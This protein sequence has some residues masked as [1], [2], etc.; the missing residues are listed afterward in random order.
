MKKKS[1]IFASILLITVLSVLLVGCNKTYNSNG[2]WGENELICCDSLFIHNVTCMDQESVRTTVSEYTEAVAPFCAK[3]EPFR[4]YT[5]V[6]TELGGSQYDPY[7]V[8]VKDNK[9]YEI[10]MVN[11]QEQLSLDYYFREEPLVLITISHMDPKEDVLIVD[12]QWFCV[13]SAANYA[14]LFN[15][16]Q[17]YGGGEITRIN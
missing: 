17:T 10:N 9:R 8:F 3:V 13:M 15:E 14:E 12:W 16:V 2:L 7:L 4:P 5:S 11:F 1:I 6:D